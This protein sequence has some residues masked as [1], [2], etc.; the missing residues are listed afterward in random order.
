VCIVF[1]AG[2]SRQ[3]AARPALPASREEVRS[4]RSQGLDGAGRELP[5][6]VGDEGRRVGRRVDV[7]GVV[8]R[9]AVFDGALQ[10]RLG[11]EGVQVDECQDALEGRTALRAA[12]A[13]IAAG[14]AASTSSASSR[15]RGGRWFGCA[16]GRGGRSTGTMA[17]SCGCCAC[18]LAG[19]GTAGSSAWGERAGTRGLGALAAASRCE[20]C[21]RR[22]RDC[23]HS[24]GPNTKK[25]HGAHRTLPGAGRLVRLAA[26]DPRHDRVPHGMKITRPPHVTKNDG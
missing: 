9:D 7:G 8:R 16:S 19:K 23:L 15:T 26:D 4:P 1:W 13:A 22:A 5:A 25:S 18:F 20:P 2:A 21:A 10:V 14:R 17:T 12:L 3:A 24:P 6:V 11:R